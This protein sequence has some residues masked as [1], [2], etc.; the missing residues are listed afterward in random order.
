MQPAGLGRLVG[1][2]TALPRSPTSSVLKINPGQGFGR[3]TGAPAV[4]A[5]ARMVDQHWQCL[6]E[7]VAEMPSASHPAHTDPI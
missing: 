1:P 5:G 7:S 6:C 3:R 2:R 4:A